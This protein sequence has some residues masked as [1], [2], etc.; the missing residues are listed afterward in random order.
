MNIIIGRGKSRQVI[1]NVPAGRDFRA[2][3]KQEPIEAAKI[4]GNMMALVRRPENAVK[5]GGRLKK[6]ITN[7]K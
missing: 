1:T 3:L 5:V 6:E 7:A 4:K 2:L